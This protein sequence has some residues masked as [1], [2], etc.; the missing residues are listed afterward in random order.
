LTIPALKDSD[1]HARRNDDTPVRTVLPEHPVD[2][3]PLHT[4]KNVMPCGE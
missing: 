3:S 1:I 4:Q 2:G